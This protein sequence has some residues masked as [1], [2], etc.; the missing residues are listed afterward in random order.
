MPEVVTN[1]LIVLSGAGVDAG[2]NGAT[3]TYDSDPAANELVD[4]LDG[5][6]FTTPVGSDG[7]TIP[8]G[9]TVTIG[10][11]EYT[12]TEAY[13]FWGE[14][15]KIDPGT[16][17]PFTDSGQTVAFTLTDGSGNEINIISPSDDFK[18]DPSLW[19]PGQI[20]EITVA[21]DPFDSGAINEDDDGTK[22][23]DDAP[24]ETACF[25][26][27]SLVDTD[28]GQKPVES[29]AVGDLVLTRDNGYQRVLWTGHHAQTNASLVARPDLAAVIVR[30]GALGGGLPL[31]DMRVSPWHRLLICGQRAEMMFGEYEVLV[32]AIH[33]VGQ[34]G[35]ARDTAPQTY[36]HLMFEEHQIIRADGAWSES[37][38]PGA[39]TLAG[40][41]GPQRDELLAL[42]PELADK[43]GQ[44]DYVAARLS[45]K[46]HEARALL[47]A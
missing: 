44:D 47:A 10:G 24:F 18:G 19:S 36:V 30:A 22:L 27:G 16:G 6:T 46:D 40:L 37:F 17:D 13:S 4:V 32:P 29:I 9:S 28:Q 20:T 2:S 35:I 38:Q 34:S 3:Y 14:F 8:T 12:L 41:G 15:T 25:V 39:K 31:R 5:V 43:A 21:S 33:M 42:F 45:L 1:D 26:A 7:E 11:T 23:G